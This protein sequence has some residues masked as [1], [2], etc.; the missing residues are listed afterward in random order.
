[1]NL[2]LAHTNILLS[3]LEPSKNGEDAVT[4]GHLERRYLEGRTGFQN[5]KI[6]KGNKKW[7]YGSYLSPLVAHDK[8]RPHE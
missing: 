7:G 5:A 3:K 8:C 2:S 1:M 6:W 4:D